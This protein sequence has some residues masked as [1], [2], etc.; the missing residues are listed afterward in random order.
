MVG[1]SF[2]FSPDA[3][4]IIDLGE[5]RDTTR[6]NSAEW[7][8]S[9][10]LSSADSFTQQVAFLITTIGIQRRKTP[11]FIA[12]MAL[13]GKKCESELGV[14]TGARQSGACTTTCANP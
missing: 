11:Y 13:R 12:R 8:Q 1:A 7:P 9:E 14:R 5:K 4:E 2:F 3:P 6:V 10:T